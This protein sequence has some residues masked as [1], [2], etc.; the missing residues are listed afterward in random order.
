MYIAQHEESMLQESTAAQHQNNERQQTLDSPARHIGPR[1]Y[2]EQQIILSNKQE[3]SRKGNIH[4]HPLQTGSFQPLLM[5]Q[6]QDND[7]EN[8]DCSLSQSQQEL[9]LAGGGMMLLNNGAHNN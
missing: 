2:I 9:M 4:H 1:E 3:D 5:L 7:N 8:E 6:Q